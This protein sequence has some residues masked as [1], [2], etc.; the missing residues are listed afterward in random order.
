MDVA[1]A[2]AGVGDVDDD[3]VRARL[4]VLEPLLAGL[5]AAEVRTL[6]GLLSRVMAGVVAEKEGGAWICRL[7]DLEA[8]GRPDGECPAANAA[9]ATY[10]PPHD[11]A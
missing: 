3:V 4:A 11:Q 7:C 8:C 10:G 6:H 9:R 5:S 2:D 1:V